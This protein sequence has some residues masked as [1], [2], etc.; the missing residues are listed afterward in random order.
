MT[1][2]RGG[3]G[4]SSRWATIAGWLAIALVVVL[5]VQHGQN[6]HRARE[7]FVDE[8]QEFKLMR[9]P[10]VYDDFYVSVY[11]DLLYNSVKNHLTLHNHSFLLLLLGYTRAKFRFLNLI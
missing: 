9:G 1:G 8:K 2:Q 3:G 5:L 4:G 10:E 6:L 7:G 11:D